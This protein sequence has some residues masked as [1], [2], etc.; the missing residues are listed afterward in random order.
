MPRFFFHFQHARGTVPDLEGV[1]LE[2]AAEVLAAAAARA[3]DLVTD[4]RHL[5]DWGSAALRVVDEDER[6]CLV[7]SLEALLRPRV[8][9]DRAA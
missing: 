1:V 3:D 4:P 2:D 8:E 5:C 7:L 6:M 9:Q